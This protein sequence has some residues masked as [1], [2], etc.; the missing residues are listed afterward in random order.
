MRSDRS[1]TRRA[2]QKLHSLVLGSTDWNRWAMVSSMREGAYLSLS[3]RHGGDRPRSRLPAGR[4]TSKLRSM[5]AHLFV[6][7]AALLAGAISLMNCGGDDSG[8]NPPPPKCVDDLN[9]DCTQ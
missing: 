3:R 4:E 8:V 2:A 6:L 1:S 7:S 5:K 9:V